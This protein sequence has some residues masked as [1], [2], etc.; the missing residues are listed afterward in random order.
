M[1]VPV[2][3][4]CHDHLPTPR[5][6]CNQL[7]DR[8]LPA[9]ERDHA[10]SGWGT[11]SIAAP[12]RSV[13]RCRRPRTPRRRPARRRATRRPATAP[14]I[15]RRP[16]AAPRRGPA[17]PRGPRGPTHGRTSPGGGSPRRA[18][19]RRARPVA[20]PRQSP[21]RR[22]RIDVHAPRAIAPGGRSR[23]GGPAAP[24][25]D[26]RRPHGRARQGRRA[27]SRDRRPPGRRIGRSAPAPP[28]WP[29][30]RRAGA[31]PAAPGPRGRALRTTTRARRTA[32]SG[33]CRPAAVAST[34]AGP[35]RPP[36]PGS[37]PA[38]RCPGGVRRRRPAREGPER[39]RLPSGTR[40]GYAATGHTVPQPGGAVWFAPPL[41]V[42]PER[43]WRRRPPRR[44][45]V[46]RRDARWCE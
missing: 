36:P 14:P 2:L 23:E 12:L 19:P 28:P 21:G 1:P 4:T 40:P 46:R 39:P 11:P 34:K 42:S 17:P 38:P 33:R 8:F 44:R 5:P 3:P 43:P 15:A 10:M 13:V 45:L 30:R 6:R 32:S 37:G 24:R 26:D 16:P 9:A 20:A 7:R 29:S 27:R 18:A 22:S 41:R 25:L 35:P 31:P